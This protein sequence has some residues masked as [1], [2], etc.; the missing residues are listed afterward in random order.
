MRIFSGFILIVGI[1][2]THLRIMVCVTLPSEFNFM[3]RGMGYIFPYTK[4][5]VDME[6]GGSIRFL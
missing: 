4:A 5:V 2:V 3:P 1:T 6:Y